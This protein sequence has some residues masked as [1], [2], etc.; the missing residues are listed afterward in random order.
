MS[1]VVGVDTVPDGQH[2]TMITVPSV[3]NTA[4]H[5]ITSASILHRGTEAQSFSGRRPHGDTA[6]YYPASVE[7]TPSMPLAVFTQAASGATILSSY[8]IM[9]DVIADQAGAG[10]N[11]PVGGITAGLYKKYNIFA[12]GTTPPWEWGL[13]PATFFP[14]GKGSSGTMSTLANAAEIARTGI[15]N[16]DTVPVAVTRVLCGTPGLT[17]WLNT[18]PYDAGA[19]A[20]ANIYF[21]LQLRRASDRA[22]LWMS[23]A[24]TARDVAADTLVEDVTVPVAASAAQ[25]TPVFIQLTAVASPGIAYALTGGFHFLEADPAPPEMLKRIDGGTN[26]AASAVHLNPASIAVAMIPNP[27]RPGTGELH[28]LVESVGTATITVYDLLG[29]AVM[30]MPG[31][32]ADHTGEYVVPVDVGRLHDGLYVAEVRMGSLR[33][34]TRFT[35][36][37]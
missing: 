5:A 30:V 36:M 37:R 10:C 4:Q 15:F 11:P 31:L 3:G 1:Y 32:V 27:V 26:R 16:A 23:T 19:G 8:N 28:V 2:P 22:V 14:P 34:T 13:P 20:P 24:I 12:P 21:V 18:Q 29:N 6:L 35:L 9:S 25:G 7:N 33:G 17:A